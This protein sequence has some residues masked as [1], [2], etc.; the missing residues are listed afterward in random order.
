[1]CAAILKLKNKAYEIQLVAPQQHNCKNYLPSRYRIWYFAYA[2]RRAARA[3][4]VARLLAKMPTL[5]LAIDIARRQF[6]LTVGRRIEAQAVDC[7]HTIGGKFPLLRM[8][9]VESKYQKSP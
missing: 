9:A 4:L 8:G 5:R 3:A 2:F 7:Q 6:R 1:M